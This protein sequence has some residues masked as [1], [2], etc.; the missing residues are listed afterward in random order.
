MILHLT[1]STK[2]VGQ[3][4]IDFNDV[5]N[6]FKA[7]TSEAGKNLGLGPL[8]TLTAGAPADLIAVRGNPFMRFKLLENPDMVI[9]GGRI[10]VNKF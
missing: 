1:H 10:V 6:V 8:G 5:V 4:E 7:V 9:S 3:P 2:P